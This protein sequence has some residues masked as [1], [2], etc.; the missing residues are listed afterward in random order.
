MLFLFNLR[1]RLNL[2]GIVEIGTLLPL[3]LK[4]NDSVELGNDKLANHKTQANTFCIDLFLFVFNGAKQFE[5][6][7]LVFF[8]NATSGVYHLNFYHVLIVVSF[9]L[10][11]YNDL[12]G[13]VSFS[14]FNSVAH[15]V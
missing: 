12:D 11:F 15:Q 9:T 1:A 5:N 7:F 8:F 13:S 3:R 4:F 6:V 10:F 2:K 14:K